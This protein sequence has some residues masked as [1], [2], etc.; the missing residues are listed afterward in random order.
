M[1]G[2]AGNDTLIGG[3]QGD[4]FYFSRG[5]NDVV[6]GNGGNDHF[7]AYKDGFKA[8]TRSTAEPATTR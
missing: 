8:T 1:T 7:W 6:E 5:G 2:G 3:A 4:T